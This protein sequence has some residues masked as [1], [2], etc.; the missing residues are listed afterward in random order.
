[1]AYWLIDYQTS[2]AADAVVFRLPYPGGNWR[3]EKNRNARLLR[4]MDLAWRTARVGY[5][6]KRKE[7]LNKEEEELIDIIAEFL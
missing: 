1:M 2:R 3:E 4:L 7:K 6:T 5:K